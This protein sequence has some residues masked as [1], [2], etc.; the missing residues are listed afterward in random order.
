MQSPR[1]ETWAFRHGFVITDFNRPASQHEVARLSGTMQWW[2]TSNPENGLGNEYLGLVLPLFANERSLTLT[3]HATGSD[4][5]IYWSGGSTLVLFKTA[6][7]PQTTPLW[8]ITALFVCLLRIRKLAEQ[9]GRKGC[10]VVSCRHNGVLGDTIF[11]PRSND[12]NRLNQTPSAGNR[13]DGQGS[14]GPG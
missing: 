13:T 7:S 6:Y 10:A 14:E 9:L 12:Y 4:D 8:T 2:P 1:L 5:H 3:K 11:K